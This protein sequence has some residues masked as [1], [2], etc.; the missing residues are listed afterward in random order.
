MR[1]KAFDWS[2]ATLT[3]TGDQEVPPHVTV[4][5]L[6]SIKRLRHR[7]AELRA[8]LGELAITLQEREQDVI[9]R[10]ENGARSESPATVLIRRRQNVSWLTVVARELG[11]ETVESTKNA[12]PITFWKELQLS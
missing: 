1:A 7:M 5:E 3:A 6:A 12:W 10:L 8:E 2:E 4:L 11:A 9:E